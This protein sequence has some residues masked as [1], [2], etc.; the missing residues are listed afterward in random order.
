MAKR[1][2]DPRPRSSFSRR[3]F[4]KLGPTAFC[5]AELP[6]CMCSSDDSG[7]TILGGA[8]PPDFRTL[9]LRKEDLVHLRF[10]FYNLVLNSSKTALVRK[11]AGAR[12]MLVTHPPQHILEE[13]LGE[14]QSLVIL[15]PPFAS[16]I[17]GTSRIAFQIPDEVG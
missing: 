16:R 12:L 11:A 5:L 14:N 15:A 9:L 7:P 10:D 17:A 2:A 13:A 8:P 1:H 6:G 3:T 4:L